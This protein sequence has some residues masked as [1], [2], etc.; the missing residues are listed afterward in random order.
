LQVIR[1]GQVT[2]VPPQTPAVQTSP[3]VQFLPSLQPVPSAAA[4]F[5]QLPLP[6]SQVPAVWHWSDA[7]QF[8][9]V[10]AHAPLPSHMSPVVHLF[11]SSQ[12][13]PAGLGA[14]PTHMPVVV[15]HVPASVQADAPE[16]WTGFVPMQTPFWHLSVCVQ[17]LPSL[18]PVPSGAGPGAEQVPVASKQVPATRHGSMGLGQVTLVPPQVPLASQTSPVVQFLPSSHGIP[19]LTAPIEQAPVMGLQA[20]AW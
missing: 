10:P 18:H 3:V 4:G 20:P 7:G 14:P 8:L 15:L 12:P 11:P 17:A 9:A 19:V 5:E 2:G 1:A 13:V 6:G 16:H